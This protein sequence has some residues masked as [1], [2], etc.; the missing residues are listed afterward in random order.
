[1]NRST[2]TR[3][4][5]VA[6]VPAALAATAL[7]LASCGDSDGDSD[8]ST[9]AGTSTAASATGEHDHA[10][11]PEVVEAAQPRILT[12][13]DGG[14]LTLDADTLDVI[15]DEK[16]EGFNRL[17][18]V[19]DGRHALVS[20][21][22]GF[23]LFDAGVW[24]EPHGDHS[25]SYATDPEFTDVVYSVDKPGHVVRHDG[26]T[27]LFSDGDGKIQVFDTASFLETTGE[28][29]APEPTVTETE[30]HHGVAIEMS[31]GTL[32][33]TEGTEEY[34][35][36]VVAV[37]ADGQETARSTECPGVHGEAAAQGEA[38]AF[39][40]EDGLLVFKD[41][42]FTKIQATEKYA[43]TG[44]Q[45]GSEESTVVLGD[46]KT[47]EDA[48]LERPTKITLTDTVANTTKVVDLGTSYSF[49]SLGRGPAGEALVLGTDGKLHV[50]DP[51]SGEETAA[52]DVIDEW[53]E[54]IEWQDARPTL[55]VQGDRAYVSDPD[56]KELHVV[57]LKSGKVLTSAELPEAPNELTGVTG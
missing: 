55:F 9:A 4:R 19:G 43:R 11:E 36:T 38:A 35:D 24:T 31:D 44:N 56:T 22:K 8:D 28:G 26:K 25:H 17:N 30:P 3:R 37:D 5:S 49:R 52:W 40:C 7:L 47:D 1:M 21:S 42:D 48:E 10:A 15:A 33:H 18:P 29:D 57:D 46:Y 39:G 14:I 16:I 45:A 32:V 51:E 54:P 53:E 6:A 13:Y 41:G 27:I 12:T 23:Q 34:R 50:L 2:R 20:T